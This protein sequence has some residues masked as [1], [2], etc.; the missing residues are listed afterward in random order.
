MADIQST[1]AAAPHIVQRED[2]TPPAWRVP[3]IAMEFDL[4]P[5]RTVVRARLSV[6][7]DGAGPL[8]LDHGGQEMR[9]VRADGAPADHRLTDTQLTIDLPGDTHLIEIECVLAPDRNTELMGLYASGGLLCTQCEAEGFRKIIPFP[10]RPDVLS[11]YLV[12]MTADK[13]RFPVLLSNGD[14]TGAGDLP[15]GRHWAEWRDPFPKPSYLFAL[16]AGDLQADR[17]STRLNSSHR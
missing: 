7:R 17:K 2:Y 12:R 10:D 4:D 16:V 5:A 13:A 8:V 9:S 15:D 6:V 14:R 11:R 1:S 3:D